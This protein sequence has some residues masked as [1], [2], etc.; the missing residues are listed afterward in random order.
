[1]SLENKIGW[2]C[3]NLVQLTSKVVLWPVTTFSDIVHST[4]LCGLPKGS[5]GWCRNRRAVEI[6][7]NLAI[8]VLRPLVFVVTS[9][10][11]KC[12]YPTS[13]AATGNWTHVSWVAPLFKEPQFR[14]LNRLSYSN[15]GTPIVKD[16][17]RTLILRFD[18]VGP[19]NVKS[20]TT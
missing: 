5:Q 16:I 3:F 2:L 20:T 19:W 4:S 14:M 17:V 11:G 15:F 18:L 13:Y 10:W 6:E 8:L 12:V 9:T 1:M 7:Q